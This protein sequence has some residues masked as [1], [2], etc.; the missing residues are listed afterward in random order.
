[1]IGCIWLIVARI[2]PEKDD[3]WMVLAGYPGTN[4]TDFEIYI[5][6]TF[7]VVATM[8]GLG[9]GNIVPTTS[10]EFFVDLFIMVTGA[11]IYANFFANF[12]VAILNRNTKKI[13]NNRRLEQAKNFAFLRN[14]P[15]DMKSKIRF[16]YTNLRIKYGDLYEKY[17][18]LHELP[19]S[20]RSELSLFIN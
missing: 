9:Y 14:L 2:D 6:S 12:A 11:S 13:E 8:T 20:L 7:Y 19:L 5:D 15:E 18:I 1:M 4:V 17:N 16:Y 3:N 10:L